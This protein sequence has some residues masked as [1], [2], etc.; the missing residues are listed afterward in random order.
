MHKNLEMIVFATV[1]GVILTL[2]AI[3]MPTSR[4]GACKTT[5]LYTQHSM[6]TEPIDPL[7]YPRKL[8]H[9]LFG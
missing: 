4:C 2:T 9:W 7:E 5:D 3:T 6:T 1:I 8:Y